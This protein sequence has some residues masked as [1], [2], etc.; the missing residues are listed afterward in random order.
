[1][2]ADTRAPLAACPSPCPSPANGLTLCSGSHS[3]GR[4]DDLPAMTREFAN[5]IHFAP[6]RNTSRQ[7]ALRLWHGH[8]IVASM[9]SCGRW[10]PCPAKLRVHGRAIASAQRKFPTCGGATNF[11][12]WRRPSSPCR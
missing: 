4:Q 9:A 6:L 8:A 1:M 12:S 11:R 2:S 7:D 3:A 10:T 5:D